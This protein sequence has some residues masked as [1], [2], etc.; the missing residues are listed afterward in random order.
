[1]L[2]VRHP[3]VS[4]TSSPVRRTL[5]RPPDPSAS[6]QRPSRPSST[7]VTSSRNSGVGPRPAVISRVRS[8]PPRPRRPGRV[9]SRQHRPRRSLVHPPRSAVASVTPLMSRS[10][11][12]TVCSRRSQLIPATDGR[13]QAA[14]PSCASCVRLPFE[15]GFCRRFIFRI[16]GDSA[17][18]RFAVLLALYT[19]IERD[20]SGRGSDREGS[21][22]ARPD[23]GEQTSET[24]HETVSL[25]T[26]AVAVIPGERFDN[27]PRRTRTETRGGV[28][29][30][31]TSKP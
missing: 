21:R 6:V 5:R 13:R 27:G 4:D 28:E 23:V 1:M 14:S 16:E 8:V 26:S 22:A 10:A 24:G 20:R 29:P 25:R 9:R 18:E 12:S 11:S 17:D 3:V 7:S 31:G 30:S 15:N 2:S 19:R